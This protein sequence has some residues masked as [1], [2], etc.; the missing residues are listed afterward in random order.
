[1]QGDWDRALEADRS[2]GFLDV[3]DITPDLR[4]ARR[5]MQK[6]EIETARG[7]IEAYLE[8]TRQTPAYG[9]LT[10][11][12]RN[13][14]LAEIYALSN[15]HAAARHH[16]ELAVEAVPADFDHVF[17]LNI[18]QRYIR[19]MALVGERDLALERIAAKLDKPEGFSRW[20]LY[21]D[22]AWDFFRDDARFNA[23]ALPDGVEPDAFRAQRRGDDT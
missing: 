9:R 2:G 15:D 7:H 18:D 3:F 4:Q 1:M 11:G 21:L 16:A 17:G 13:I 23:L 14:N 8:H 19:I 22:P 12:F 20:E 6:G 10:T 5:Y